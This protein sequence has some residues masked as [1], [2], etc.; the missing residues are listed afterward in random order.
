MVSLPISNYISVR[1]FTFDM[2]IKNPS[3][4]TIVTGF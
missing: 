1:G 2:L 4:E 3:F